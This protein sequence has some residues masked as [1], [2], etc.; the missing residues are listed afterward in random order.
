MYSKRRSDRQN[1]TFAGLACFESN[2]ASGQIDIIPSKPGKISK[3]L[4]CVETK[5]DQAFPFVVCYF[6]NA[7]NLGNRKRAPEILAILPHRVNKFCRIL[8]NVS[9]SCARCGEAF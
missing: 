2:L 8:Q 6:Q 7:P 4:P 5:K 9:V 3:P 1:K